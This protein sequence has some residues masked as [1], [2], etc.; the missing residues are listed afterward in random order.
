[1]GFRKDA[2]ASVWSVEE[3]RGNTMK[4][5][6]STSKKNKD[7][8]YEQDFSGFCSFIG[9]AKAKAEKLKEKDRIKL[10]DVEV[11][12]WY[13]KDNGKEYV[14]YKVFDFEMSNTSSQTDTQTSTTGAKN[15]KCSALEDVV[16]DGDVSED[17]LPF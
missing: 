13:N 8:E 3:G 17:N 12:T 4:V 2:W 1:M 16:E 11:T 10:G 6:I 15:K 7:G 9:N 14:T 5:R